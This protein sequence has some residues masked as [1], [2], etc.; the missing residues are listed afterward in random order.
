MFPQTS[1]LFQRNGGRRPCAARPR[2]EQLE[3]RA[4]PAGFF[5][6]GVG[7][8]TSPAEPFAR[9][10]DATSPGN[11]S[12]VVGAGNMNAFP[13]FSGDVRVAT[14]DVNGD[15]VVD[16]VTAAGPTGGPNVRVWDGRD[17]SLMRDFFAYP[18]NFTGGVYVAAGDVNGDGAADVITGT[19]PGAAAQIAVFDGRSGGEIGRFL[20]YD[21]NF[22]GGVRVAAGD[23]NG[24]GRDEIITG[25]AD[26]CSSAG[27]PEVGVAFPALE[28]VRSRAFNIV[29]PGATLQ[30]RAAAIAIHD[31]AE[32]AALDF[33]E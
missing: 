13:G 30:L 29:D 7:G 17:G 11:S 9:I 20:A 8:F 18:A 32:L 33:F 24:D 10:Y 26:Y 27:Q 14:G 12:N 4:T 3:D 31:A 15:G 25:A 22:F 5:L 19:G 1:R 23:V 28:D 2:L 21:A 16:L 6:T